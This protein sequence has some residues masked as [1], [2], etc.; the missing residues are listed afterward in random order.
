MSA[1]KWI[2]IAIVVLIVLI[3]LFSLMSKKRKEA[4]REEAANL[5]EEAH[6]QQPELRD[7][8]AKAAQSRANADQL[9]AEAERKQAEAD[10]MNVK[11]DKHESSYRSAQEE[12]DAQLRKADE[13]DPD[14]RTDGNGRRLDR[15]D[16][17]GRDGRRR[18]DRPY[19]HETAP[20][21]GGYD[22]T[23]AEDGPLAGRRNESHGLDN[24]HG[25]DDAGFSGD[26]DGQGF[27]RDQRDGARDGRDGGRGFG[28]DERRDDA[29]FDGRSDRF[30][31][32]QLRDD[33][34]EAQAQT[35]DERTVDQGP[36]YVD[37]REARGQEVNGAVHDS[38]QDA[39]GPHRERRSLRDRVEGEW[40][41]RRAHH[42]E[43]REERHPD[44][45]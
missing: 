1:V 22:Q 19:D 36:G 29:P 39:D 7:R 45:R 9:R 32:G 11:A 26:R 33:R 23:S 31:D 44:D 34:G 6:G 8:E 3:A 35:F 24:A 16:A 27:G 5:R 2:I 43:R 13:L 15:D 20:A 12:H 38:Q 10:R 4:H 28:R 18:D 17:D 40:D 21:R 30:N 25:R 14:V 41:E 42:E 37:E